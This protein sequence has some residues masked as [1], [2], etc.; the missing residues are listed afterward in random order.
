MS[1]SAP[2]TIVLVTLHAR[3]SAQAVPLAAASVAAALPEK[4]RTR[5]RLL[6]LF[7]EDSETAALQKILA[8]APGLVA[9]PLYSWS[10]PRSLALARRLRQADPQ[11]L[12]AADGPEA[13]AD[14]EGVLEE[15]ELDAVIRGEGELS[16][17]DLASDFAAGL[18]LAPHP[19][20]SLRSDRGIVHGPER[21][22]VEDLAELPSP[23]LSGTL[24]VPAGG[25]LWEIARGCP[26]A[27]DFCYDARG[28]HG[29]RSIPQERLNA[30]LDELLRRKVAQVWILDSTFNYPPR[31]GKK[32][33]RLLAEKAPQIHFHLEAKAEFLDKETAALLSRLT[34]SVQIGLQSAR[35]EVL[36]Q[37][38]RTLDR[39]AFAR[40]VHLLAAEGV[41]YGLDLIYGLP[42]DDEGGF[43]ESLDFALGLAP[44][45]LD[46]F[47]LAVLPGTPLH[48][49]RETLGIEA[50]DRPPYEIIATP[51]LSEAAM[52]RCRR[53]AAATDIVYNAGRAVGFFGSLLRVTEEA[54]SRFLRD[55]ADWALDRQQIAR[56]RFFDI[57][58][59][60][61]QEILGVQQRYVSDKLREI[62][63][64]EL[65]QAARDL[66]RYHFHYAETLLGPETPAQPAST[67]RDPWRSAWQLAPGIRLVDFAYEI[68]DLLEMGEADIAQ[69]AALFRPVGSTALFARRG[70]QVLCESLEE[71]FARLLRGCDGQRTPRE[72]FGDI[73]SA[74]EGAEIAEFAVAEGLLVEPP[75]ENGYLS[76]RSMKP[77]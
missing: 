76:R 3:R 17:R 18:P 20:V 16:F 48:R 26:F 56:E 15:G 74:R 12:L 40:Q 71:D 21:P 7:P 45:H 39:E 53:L 50:M 65:L 42:G 33:L 67:R 69:F 30:E 62:G 38:H 37:I 46:I 23:W 60:Q 77:R 44:N 4:L 31:R 5:T 24:H 68:L 70:E 25:A 1:P 11:L 54:P 64:T 10:R 29:V 52:E 22:P 47:P 59:W 73:I 49:D 34:C 19:G 63:R 72:I 61:P 2:A 14:P 58:Q 51:T 8:L 32:L 35:P 9:F 66:L 36:R 41:T 28:S 27:C 43:A 6:D 55:F 57:H 13:T 75:A